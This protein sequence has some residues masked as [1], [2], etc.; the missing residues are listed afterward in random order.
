MHV[1]VT[2]VEVQPGKFDTVIAMFRDELIP[3]MKRRQGFVGVTVF[4]DRAT[5]K[6]GSITY[7]ASEADAQATLADGEMQGVVGAMAQYYVGQATRESYDVLLD[8]R[9]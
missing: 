4:G 2:S 1:R 8:E 7:Y 6:G 9:T 3:A 5:G